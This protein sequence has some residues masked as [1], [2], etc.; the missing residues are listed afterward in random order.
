MKRQFLIGIVAALLLVPAAATAN[1]FSCRLDGGA[2]FASFGNVGNAIDA[3]ILQNLGRVDS[4]T[5]DCPSEALCGSPLSGD[6]FR[7]NG[8]TY[9]DDATCCEANRVVCARFAPAMVN[10]YGSRANKGRR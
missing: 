10:C 4:A 7:A 2:G 1:D 3:S 8:S 6:C 9:C 5:L